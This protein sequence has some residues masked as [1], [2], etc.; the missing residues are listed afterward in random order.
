MKIATGSHTGT[1]LW[2][3]QRATALLLVLALPFLLMYCLLAL[4]LDFN[5]WQTLWAPL[6]SRVLL[7]MSGAALALHAWVG[8]RDILMDYVHC[9][10]LKLAMTLVVMV[11]LAS[12]LVWLTAILFG[13]N[14]GSGA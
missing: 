10:L 6:W 3:M 2:L 8:M 5:G 1:G 11:V 4:P 14:A 9:T 7:V 12:S 13:S